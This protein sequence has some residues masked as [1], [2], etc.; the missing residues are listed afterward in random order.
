MIGRK[1]ILRFK[2]I[3]QKTNEPKDQGDVN[4]RKIEIK[5]NMNNVSRFNE[6]VK[7]THLRGGL[8]ARPKMV[9]LIRQILMVQIQK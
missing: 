6:L 7:P 2:F 8:V 3:L 1:A 4:E 5:C 9:G